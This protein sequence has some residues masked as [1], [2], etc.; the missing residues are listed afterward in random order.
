LNVGDL[1]PKYDIFF[2]CAFLVDTIVYCIYELQDAPIKPLIL[3]FMD[4]DIEE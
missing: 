1:V 4:K 2:P 3:G